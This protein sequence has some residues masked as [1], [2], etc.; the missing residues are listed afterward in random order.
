[1]DEQDIVLFVQLNTSKN[2]FL[3]AKEK[4]IQKDKHFF[5]MSDFDNCLKNNEP[6]V[7]YKL[8]EVKE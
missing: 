6:F 7:F 8:Y 5:D 3:T 1:M 4:L 2:N